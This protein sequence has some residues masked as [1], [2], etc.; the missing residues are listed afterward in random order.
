MATRPFWRSATRVRSRSLTP[1]SNSLGLLCLVSGQPW[2]AVR[3]EQRA[4]GSI[5]RLLRSHWS[6]PW[7]DVC[8]CTDA[9]ENC[10]AFTVHDGCRELCSEVGRVSER[11]RFHR[12]VQICSCQVAYAQGS[13][14][15]CSSSGE[16]NVSHARRESRADFPEVSW[17][18]LEHQR[19]DGCGYFCT[20]PFRSV[21]P[22]FPSCPPFFLPLFVFAPPPSFPCSPSR[23]PTHTTRTRI[24]TR[25][26]AH[27][28]DHTR[29]TA[30]H[31]TRRHR[32]RHTQTSAPD[33]KNLR[34]INT[35]KTPNTDRLQNTTHKNT[36]NFVL[37]SRF[38]CG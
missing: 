19:G 4:F 24:R 28:T 29:H 38:G 5:L 7:L 1:V 36:P 31:R 35:E 25:T 12:K 9:S 15:Q 23:L 20:N 14:S 16:E 13:G 21:F 8:I 11:T 17:R 2:S 10:F 6:L 30:P 26:H 33:I 32:H 27:F 37:L 3:Q 22:V 18:L 34:Y